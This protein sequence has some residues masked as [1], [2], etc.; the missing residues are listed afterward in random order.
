MQTAAGIA[1]VGGEM[2]PV[3]TIDS[4]LPVPTKDDGFIASKRVL[5]DEEFHYSLIVGFGFQ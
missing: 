4:F 1:R 5:S 3:R 2:P